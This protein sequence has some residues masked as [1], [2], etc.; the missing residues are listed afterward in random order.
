M[1]APAV[2]RAGGDICFNRAYNPGWILLHVGIVQGALKL[3]AETPEK[4][5]KKDKM[6]KKKKTNTTNPHG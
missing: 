3:I 1:S 4:N 5:E 6:N 2:G